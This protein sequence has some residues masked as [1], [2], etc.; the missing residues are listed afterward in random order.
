MKRRKVCVVITARPSYSRI[1]SVLEAIRRV[2]GSL[3]L[4]LVV[5]ASALLDRYGNAQNVI[6]K[7]GFRI[8][9]RVY[10]ILEGENLVTSAKS[11]GLG[12]AELATVFDDLAPDVVITIADR[13]ETL[14]TAVAASYLNIPLVHIQGG[15]VTGSIDESVRHAITKLAHVHFPATEQAA[16]YLVRMGERPE[17]VFHTGCPSIDAIATLDLSL[18]PDLFQRYGG[19]GARIDPKAPYLVVLQHP[20]TTEYGQGMDQIRH[21]LEAVHRT[22]M[23]T[24]WL[25]P[26]VDAGSDHIAKGLREFREERDA[27]KLHFF[28]NFA[29]EDYARLIVNCACLVGNSSSALREGAFL[30][31]PA[32]NIGTRQTGRECGENVLHVG[33]D[34]AEIHE[35]IQTQIAHGPHPRNTMFGDGCAGARIAEVLATVDI[36]VQKSLAYSPIERTIGVG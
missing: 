5:A 21:T 31:V 10:M 20:V 25:W 18:P 8:D 9:R 3:E 24:V 27:S 36:Q 34:A 2:D 14:A 1:K 17:R 28:R 6:E 4:Q 15:E 35:A 12:M 23:Q 29:V 22:G 26:N 19:V 11:T 32:V 16:E 7:E 13:F 30:G 33:H